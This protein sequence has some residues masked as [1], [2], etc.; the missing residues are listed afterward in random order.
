MEEPVVTAVAPR[1]RE[2]EVSAME[3]SF[4]PRVVAGAVPPAGDIL[5]LGSPGL[6]GDAVWLA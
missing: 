1:R 5:I 2:V 4:T 3:R 6:Y